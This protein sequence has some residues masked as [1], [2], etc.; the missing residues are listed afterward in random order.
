MTKAQYTLVDQAK[1]LMLKTLK[2][3]VSPAEADHLVLGAVRLL[4]TAMQGVVEK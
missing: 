4:E 2:N 3:G 1:E